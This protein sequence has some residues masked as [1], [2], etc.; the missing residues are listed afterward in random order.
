MEKVDRRKDERRGT[1]RRE[2][3]QRI[4]DRLKLPLKGSVVFTVEGAKDE[5]DITVRDISAFGTYFIADFR[6][7]VSE[8]ITLHL[9]LEEAGGSF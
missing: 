3:D 8:E 1:V 7:D 6:P 9:P 4:A 2:L 5:R